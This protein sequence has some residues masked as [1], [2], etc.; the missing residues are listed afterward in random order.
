MR[1]FDFQIVP[2]DL[3]FW[4]YH[5]RTEELKTVANPI[6]FLKRQD[7]LFGA[8]RGRFPDMCGFWDSSGQI[9]WKEML[10]VSLLQMLVLVYPLHVFGGVFRHMFSFVGQMCSEFGRDLLRCGG[11]SQG[12]IDLLSCLWRKFRWNIFV[13]RNL[14]MLDCKIL[15]G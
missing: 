3:T 2:L 8:R 4:G 5:L 11:S 10:I 12:F 15:N 9:I 7:F 14:T 1:Y 6:K 13:C